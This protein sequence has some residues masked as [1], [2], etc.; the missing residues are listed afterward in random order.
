MKTI[1][2]RE[3]TWG[4]CFSRRVTVSATPCVLVCWQAVGWGWSLGSDIGVTWI[5]AVTEI[6]LCCCYCWWCFA[7]R[8]LIPA[9]ACRFGEQQHTSRQVWRLCSKCNGILHWRW[10]CV[11]VAVSWLLPQSCVEDCVVWCRR[12]DGWVNLNKFCF[13]MEKSNLDTIQRITSQFEIVITH[14][15]E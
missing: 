11:C 12:G 13:N 1:L 2:L 6:M 4:Q 10:V 14:Q 15:N 8:D 3:D 5:L 7:C 9:N